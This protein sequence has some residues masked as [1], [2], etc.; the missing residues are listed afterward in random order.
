[1]IGNMKNDNFSFWLNRIKFAAKLF[2]F[3]RVDHFRAFDTYYSIPSYCQTAEIGEWKYAYGDEI[4]LN[5]KR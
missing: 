1:M 3:V 4:F 5:L 2:S